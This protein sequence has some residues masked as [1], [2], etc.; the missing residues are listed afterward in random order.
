MLAVKFM[1]TVLQLLSRCV[2][3]ES[4]RK[5]CVSSYDGHSDSILCGPDVSGDRW[6]AEY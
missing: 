4:Q 1:D 5:R 3:I 2:N 6:W